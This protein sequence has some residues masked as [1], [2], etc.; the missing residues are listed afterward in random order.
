MILVNETFARRY[1][2]GGNPIGQVVRSLAS[3]ALALAFASSH[4]NIAG[5]HEQSRAYAEE[6]IAF[7]HEHQLDYWIGMGTIYR[8]FATAALGDG[9]TGIA[10]MIEGIGRHTRFGSRLGSAFCLALL[11]E[12]H[13]FA[14]RRTQAAA[15][16]TTS[17]C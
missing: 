13:L 1:F 10:Q 12:A 9:E 6:T 4:Y 5:D 3:L 16:R 14:G 8:G 17:T 7:A 2:D 11:G 15:S